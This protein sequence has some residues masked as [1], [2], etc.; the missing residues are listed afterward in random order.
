MLEIAPALAA[1]LEPYRGRTGSVLPRI[2]NDQRSS[3]RRLDNLRTKV[4][5]ALPNCILGSRVGSDTPLAVISTQKLGT[6]ISLPCKPG[7]SRTSC[8]RITRALVTGTEAQRF[9]AIRFLR[10]NSWTW[11]NA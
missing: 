8:T 1:F 4:E 7:T 6:R 5:K 10:R 3:V 2:F 11:T 9:W